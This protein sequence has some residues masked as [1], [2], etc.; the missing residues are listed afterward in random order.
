MDRSA[1]ILR[2]GHIG[3]CL[4]A[5]LRSRDKMG[6][7]GR[8]HV[9]LHGGERGF[10]GEAGVTDA[11]PAPPRGLPGVAA[12]IVSRVAVVAGSRGLAVRAPVAVQDLST[13]A[14]D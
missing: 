12:G 6:I 10:A 8:R 2:V 14:V 7:V 5:D 4:D 9:G 13:L 3:A 1:D 11:H